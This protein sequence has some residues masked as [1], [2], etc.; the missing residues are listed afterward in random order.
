MK[1]GTTI[2][3]EVYSEFNNKG[4]FNPGY[5]FPIPSAKVWFYGM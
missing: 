3:L 2:T 4:K 1:N 5:R